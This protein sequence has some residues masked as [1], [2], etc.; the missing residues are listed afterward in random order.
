MRTRRSPRN[1]ERLWQALGGTRPPRRKRTKLL[2][3][4]EARARLFPQG[5][6]EEVQDELP[7]RY[8]K[9]EE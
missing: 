8:E 4:A 3:K 1:Q 9:Q 5:E 6:I 2:S 7:R